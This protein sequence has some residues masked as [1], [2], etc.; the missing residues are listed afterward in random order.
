MNTKSSSP[1]E[2]YLSSCMSK[3]DGWSVQVVL[4]SLSDLNRQTPS[5]PFSLVNI[6]NSCKDSRTVYVSIS[7]KLW[8][9]DADLGLNLSSTKLCVFS[10]ITKLDSPSLSFFIFKIITKD[11]CKGYKDNQSF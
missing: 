3:S 10:K 5:K 7:Q 11:D 8:L 9:P 6:S 4:F 2:M 1:V